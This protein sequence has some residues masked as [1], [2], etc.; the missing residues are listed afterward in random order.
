MSSRQP[1]RS[2]VA[3]L[4]LAL[5]L[6]AFECRTMQGPPPVAP[7]L[8]ESGAPVQAVLENWIQTTET[9]R[10]AAT[11]ARAAKARRSSVDPKSSV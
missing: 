1:C 6:L 11:E 7:A 2:P 9:A 10:R 3:L 5:P 8:D 4:A